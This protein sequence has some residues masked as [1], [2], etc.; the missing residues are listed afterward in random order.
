MTD[1]P[2]GPSSQ[3]GAGPA[4]RTR[5]ARAGLMVW[6][7]GLRRRRRLAMIGGAMLAVP[8]LWLLALLVVPMLSLGAMS[9]A[10]RS[11]YG[12]VIWQFTTDNFLRMLGSTSG[13]WSADYLLILGRSV[14]IALVTTVICV[15]VAYPMAVFIASR[16]P[17]MRYIWLTLVIIPLCTNLVIRTYAWTLLLGSQMPP[18]QLAH[19]LGWLEPGRGLYPSPLAVYIGMVT[20]CLPFAVLPIYSNVEHMDWSIVEAVRDL[21]GGRRLVFVHGILP[22]TLPGLTAAIILTFIPAMGAFVVPDLLG[23]AKTWLVGN[24]I[25]QQFGPSR[26]WPFGSAVSL[27]LIVLSL[28]GLVLMRRKDS[29]TVLP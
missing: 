2:P 16:R 20:S 5:A 17:R 26:D 24:L 29:R 10:R 23:G 1:L 19:W 3:A 21:Y 18:A 12:E 11:P 6:Y 8:A 13:G 9:F 7:G 15:A 28:A 25:Q 4:V 22:Q 27:G 14:W